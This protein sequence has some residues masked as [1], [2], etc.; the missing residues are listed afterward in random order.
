VNRKVGKQHQHAQAVA[1][2]FSCSHDAAAAGPESGFAGMAARID[3]ILQGAGRD[4]SRNLP[5]SLAFAPISTPSTEIGEG[6][7]ALIGWNVL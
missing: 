3:A 2:L 5:G 4:D 1:D 7:N 6:R